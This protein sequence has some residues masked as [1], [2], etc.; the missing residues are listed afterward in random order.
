MMNTHISFTHFAPPSVNAHI[1]SS[2]TAFYHLRLAVANIILATGVAPELT[3]SSQRKVRELR[4]TVHHDGNKV[5]FV[6]I[7]GQAVTVPK[8]GA[9]FVTQTAIL[10][11]E[12]MAMMQIVAELLRRDLA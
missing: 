11:S 5:T 3:A 10:C 1:I 7:V 6:R 9:V 2:L 12:S 8:Q 4:M